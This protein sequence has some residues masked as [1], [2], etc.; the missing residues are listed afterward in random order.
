MPKATANGGMR[1]MLAIALPMVVSQGC[2]TVMIFSGRLFLS[3]LG[4]DYMNAVMAGGLTVFMLM[5]F[6]VGLISYATAL[7]AQ[8]LGAGLKKNCELVVT[9]GV[10]LSIAVFVPLLA[11]RPLIHHWFASSGIA[12]AQLGPQIVYFD[13]LFFSVILTLIK[14]CFVS[15]F[16]GIGRT[17]VVMTASLAA[18]TVNILS[19][20]V[21]IFGRFGV[22]AM[23]I[24]GAA[25]GTILGALAG[26]AV[27]LK[28]YL[29]KRLRLEFDFKKSLKF[30]AGTMKKLLYFGSPTG[31][32]LFL[33]IFAFNTM[34]MIFHSHSPV[35]ATAAT[36]L[37]NWDLVSFVPLLGIEIGVTS[38]V[39]RYMGARDPDS[40][41]RSVL[42]G[43]KMALIYSSGILLLFIGATHG[44]VWM[45]AP[46]HLS[47]VFY[48]AAP[49]AMFMVR[50]AAL[51]V[52]TDALLVVFIGA[53]RGAGDTYWA[54]A[55]SVSLHWLTVTVLFIS[56]RMLKLTPQQSWAA[57]VSIF[58]I[59][60]FFAWLRYRTGK[61]RAIR[62]ID[63]GPPVL[64]DE[65]PQG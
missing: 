56:L 26:L 55:I 44:L 13:I 36:I 31:L 39:G 4:P 1:Q 21:L 2:D 17:G 50:L 5:S 27:L 15:F 12:S 33:N 8:Y 28:A 51:Y 7:V 47:V 9:Q 6:F 20:F 10:L 45:F 64:A 62:V 65:I 57:V 16:S 48:K 19:S 18:M 60:S 25:L 35:T 46:D 42:S 37:F 24:R 30:D 3:K 61:W 14:C 63:Q 32:E 38:M 34:V 54:M 29:D 23:G 58:V 22:P 43:L 59:C 41:N 11:L 49:L 40:A 53:L 52:M